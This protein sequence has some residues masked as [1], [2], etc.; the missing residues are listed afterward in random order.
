MD[1]DGAMIGVI[2]KEE[3]LKIAQERE[4]DLIEVSPNANPPV[5]KI[6][7]Y[8]KFL[9]QEQKKAKVAKG[10]TSDTKIIKVKLGTSEH[11][12]EQKAKKISEFLKAKDRV[13]INLVLRGRSKGVDRNFAQERMERILK[14]I[15]E[16]YKIASPAKSG[17]AG[18]TITIEHSK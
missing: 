15:T 17:P 10:S 16:S 8:G 5:A 7:E 9:Y 6:M 3:A 2:S 12:L 11:D 13:I 18:V 14:F 4:L 1:E